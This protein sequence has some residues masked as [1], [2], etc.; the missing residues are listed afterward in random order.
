MFL[1]GLRQT[2]LTNAAFTA[3]KEESEQP[4]D[5]N[6]SQHSHPAKQPPEKGTA[7]A[8]QMLCEK[9]LGSRKALRPCAT[10]HGMK[11]RPK[12][13]YAHLRGEGVTPAAAQYVFKELPSSRGRSNCTGMKRSIQ[14]WK[15]DPEATESTHGNCDL[16]S[17]RVVN[18]M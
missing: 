7:G 12:G 15:F 5:G 1:I 4:N 18:Q 16:P 14:G 3:A 17:P 13:H 6:S 10:K 2:I 8:D 9:P 11:P